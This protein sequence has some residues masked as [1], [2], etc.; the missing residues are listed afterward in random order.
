M[1]LCFPP[2]PSSSFG[3]MLA[4][5]SLGRVA[6]QIGK[7]IKLRTSLGFWHLMD[8]V[9]FERTT[10]PMQS[11]GSRD[12][13]KPSICKAG[14]LGLIQEH[15]TSCFHPSWWDSALVSPTAS[16]NSEASVRGISVSTKSVK[17]TDDCLEQEVLEWEMR[18]SLETWSPYLHSLI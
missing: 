3:L 14:Q 16:L 17:A 6:K 13:V 15:P 7:L 10:L 12:P 18:N 9:I 5:M 1:Q 4:Q 11:V 8:V 2:T